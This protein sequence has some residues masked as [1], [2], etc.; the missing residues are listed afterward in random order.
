[1]SVYVMYVCVYISM[2]V[3]MYARAQSLEKWLIAELEQGKLHD[4]PE[5]ADGRR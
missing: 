1:M 5:K 4:V 2:D 3:W